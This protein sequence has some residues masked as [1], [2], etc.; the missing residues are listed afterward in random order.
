[1][2]AVGT[3]LTFL[4]GSLVFLPPAEYPDLALDCSVPANAKADPIAMP[5]AT[6]FILNDQKGNWLED[7][8]DVFELW[9][10]DALRGRWIDAEGNCFSI[11]RIPRKVPDDGSET[12]TRADYA[13][14][15]GDAAP[16]G[17]AMLGQKDLD[18]LDEAVYLLAPVEVTERFAP[19]RSQRKNLA[20]LWQ[21]SS[22]N[23]NAYVYAF[24]PRVAGRVQTDWY[25][26]S[27]VSF[28]PEA[29]E[30][31]DQWLDEVEWCGEE[32]VPG[33]A[34][35]PSKEAPRETDL[36]AAD[37]R[38]NVI[39]YEDWHFASASNIVVVDNMT[40]TDRRP[41]LAA[42]TNGFPRLQA[43]YRAALPSPLITDSHIAAVRIF[44]SREEYLNYVG[45][46]MKWSAALWSP[47]HRE[48]V[49]FYPPGGSETLL[50]TV[51]HEAL[52]QHLDYA[53]SMIQTPPWFNEGHAELFE[54]THFNMD[55]ELVFDRN[56]D[57]VLAI[58]QNAA[59]LAESLP[60]LLDMDYSEFYAGT[61]AER[62]LK[63]QLAWSLAYFLQV[64]APKVR[65]Q[66]F[67]N[68]R[69]DLMAA[70]V[71]TR[72]RDEAMRAVLGG[73][74]RKS[75]MEEWTAFWKRQ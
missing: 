74:M 33:Q 2:C 63:Y 25:M 56:P 11:C 64:G 66:P 75:L 21:Y 46:E 65:F 17:E 38:R 30:K 71:R 32:T 22:T 5:S 54:H 44:G 24:R 43:A 23:D 70:V 9:R 26:V 40:E 28:D 45:L 39:N 6:A 67:K 31:I 14:R 48:L 58:Q 68:L 18:H 3:A 42:L 8:F 50:R 7:R 27:L 60:T 53:C 69:M 73:A 10:A 1:M 62:Q 49:L 55:G 37:Y 12:R 4:F 16:A 15:H 35:R 20:A 59:V 47:Q 51:W 72:R 52:H 13:V 34:K 57:A 41:F 61:S 29:P 36:L 19:R